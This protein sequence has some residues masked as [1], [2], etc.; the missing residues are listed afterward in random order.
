MH[1]GGCLEGCDFFIGEGVH[2][3]VLNWHSLVMGLAS[4][5]NGR[6]VER[7]GLTAMLRAS[8][9]FYGV[10]S[11][12]LLGVVWSTGGRPPLWL[13]LVVLAGVLCSHAMTIPNMT[14]SAMDPMGDIAGMASAI[15]GAVLIGGGAMIGSVLDRRYDGTVLPL[16]V[17]FFASAVIV[18]LLVRASERPVPATLNS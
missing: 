7:Y 8:V 13:Y 6:I 12:V 9:G 15:T 14:S 18:A 1:L 3:D 4:V 2:S 10:S 5:A 11:A 17:A 16:S